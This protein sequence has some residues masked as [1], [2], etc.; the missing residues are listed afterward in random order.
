MPVPDGEVDLVE[1]ARADPEAFG[2]LYD[3]YFPSIYRFVAS[4]LPDQ[5]AAEDVT[6]EVFMK[7]LRSIGGYRHQG[8][9][10]SAWLY[11][12]AINAIRDRHRSRRYQLTDELSAAIASAEAPVEEQVLM[13]AEARRLWAL[14]ERLPEAQRHAMVLRFQQDL[15][16]AQVAVALRRSEGAVKLLIHRAVQR[17]RQ[18]M[19]EGVA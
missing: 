11:Q 5:S 3:R 7:A 9:P 4:R 18:E 14:V 19:A 13:N 1:R 8:H 17:I 6:A 12:I 10:F 15:S 2:R 16:T